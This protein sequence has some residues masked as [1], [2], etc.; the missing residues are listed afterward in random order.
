VSEKDI[1]KQILF[2][3]NLIVERNKE[4]ANKKQSAKK[5]IEDSFNTKINEI[6]SKIRALTK[7]DDDKVVGNAKK[8]ERRKLIKSLKS[9]IKALSR[10]K[11]TTL[12]W[13]LNDINKEKKSQI[14]KLKAELKGLKR[15]LTTLRR[16]R[17]PSRYI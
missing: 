7:S 14:K 3:R 15:I 9:E 4:Y 13:K 10:K 5:E 8:K 6:K 11:S 1:R 16:S 17:L 12:K 2:C